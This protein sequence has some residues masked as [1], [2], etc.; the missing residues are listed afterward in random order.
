[1]RLIEPA[2]ATVMIG[3]VALLWTL[4]FAGLA[5]AVMFGG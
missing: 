3:F 5:L 2:E 1:M 4:V